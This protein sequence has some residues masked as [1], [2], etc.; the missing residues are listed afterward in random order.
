MPETE[1]SI[2]PHDDSLWQYGCC[3]FSRNRKIH[4]YKSKHGFSFLVSIGN[5]VK[6]IKSMRCERND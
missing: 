3:E 6:C 4:I 2:A 1:I 5:K